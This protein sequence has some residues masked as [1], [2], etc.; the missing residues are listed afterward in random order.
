MQ[1]TRCCWGLAQPSSNPPV[2]EEDAQAHEDNRVHLGRKLPWAKGDEGQAWI[3]L[4]PHQ[5][6]AGSTHVGEG[7]SSSGEE[8]PLGELFRNGHLQEETSLRRP[9]LAALF[10]LLSSTLL[11]EPTPGSKMPME[12]PH[13][14]KLCGTFPVFSFQSVLITQIMC[15]NRSCPLYN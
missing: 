15:L 13:R 7:T 10:H 6:S 2:R 3:Y 11:V 12:R 14:A 9:A 5:L 8:H 1:S 4:L